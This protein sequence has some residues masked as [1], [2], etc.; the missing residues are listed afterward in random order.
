MPTI[1]LPIGQHQIKLIVYDGSLYSNPDYVQITVLQTGGQPPVA[2]AGADKTA[3][4][5]TGG[6]AS[7][8]LNGSGSYDP[9][10]SPLQYSWTWTI[11]AQTFSA[12]GVTP[13][14]Q[15][16][17]GQHQIKLIVYDGS[18]YSNPDYVQITVLQTGGQPPVANAGAD[19]NVYALAGGYASVALDGSGSY[20]P[21]G[22]SLQYSW[23]WTIGTQ[24]Y[25]ATGAKPT[26]QLPVGQYQIS[27][28]VYD[29]NLYSNPDYV[30]ITVL[31]TGGQP[32]VA[33]AGPDKTAYA[34]AGEFVDVTLDGSGSYDPEGSPLQY[35]WTWT[36]GAQNYQATSVNPTIQ[37]PVGEH[38]ISLIV[39]D[40]TTYSTADHVVVTVAEPQEYPLRLW[41][42]HVNRQD[43]SLY[44]LV[45][46]VLPDISA[47]EIDL[48]TPLLLY[49]GQVQAWAQHA[50]ETNN[51][52][53]STTVF[54]MFRE[55]DLLTAIPQ[56]GVVSLTVMGQF[57]FGQ[58][59]SGTATVILT[60]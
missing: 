16:T 3:Y 58:P 52:G 6:Y 59:Y 1:Q 55:E 50:T 30:R 4:A 60:H 46:I 27:L 44:L 12:T 24:T 48:T 21:E 35:S 9:D 33:N 2:N 7:V 54:A 43:S 31:Q 51:G 15:L 22:S 49:P 26:I 56:D 36:I 38:I 28:I 45:L 57:I 40:G 53:V 14:I 13:T 39:F 17:V 5:P 32:P 8:A 23:T 25:H 20:D 42:S 41:P 37:L 18:L 19:K 10:G 29:G 11:G 47:G 34:L